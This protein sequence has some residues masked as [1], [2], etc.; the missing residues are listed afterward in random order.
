M[1]DAFPESPQDVV[2]R[3]AA[4]F[5]S[6][7]A[8][9]PDYPLAAVRWVLDRLTR[10]PARV[11]DLAAGTGKLT[12]VLRAAGIPAEAITAVEPDPAM[13]A[14]LRRAHPGVTALEGTAERIPLPDGAVD[15]V[16][17]G[18][19]MHWF[20]MDRAYPE[21]HR[22]LASGGVLGGFWNLDDDAVPWV[23]EMKR[24]ARS[25]VTATRWRP[26]TLPDHPLFPH[27][28]RTEF[29]HVQRR[30][31]ESMAATIGTHSHVLIMDEPARRDLL[32]RVVAH[33]RATPET[34]D[35][36]FDLP[37]ITL[38]VRAVAA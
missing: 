19:A 35:G 32:E 7:A 27:L 21:M 11:L 34:A 23:A 28:E 30:T 36:D 29:P 15:A 38:A 2:A 12:G 16:L 1:Q 14:E 17:V 26:K 18:Q 24:I 25:T 20:D 9:R 22:V 33:L 8:E 4:S 6:N 13:L 31:A 37:L 3:R 10:R 5:G